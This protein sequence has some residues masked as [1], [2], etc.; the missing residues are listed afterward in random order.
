MKRKDACLPDQRQ[1]QDYQTEFTM[2]GT[3]ET[4]AEVNPA[5]CRSRTVQFHAA[6]G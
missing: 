5:T 3:V 1:W 6:G 4:E 2:P